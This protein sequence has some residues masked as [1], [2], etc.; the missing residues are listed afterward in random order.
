VLS[1]SCSEDV[2]RQAFVNR[3][4]NLVRRNIMSS[5]LIAFLVLALVRFVLPV[6]LVFSLG[7]VFAPKRVYPTA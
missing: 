6:V 5:E 2:L 7:A 3:F 1:Y 4:S